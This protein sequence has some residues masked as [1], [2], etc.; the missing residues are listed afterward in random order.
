MCVR[1]TNRDTES[2]V[3]LTT[4]ARWGLILLKGYLSNTT[5]LTAMMGIESHICTHIYVHPFLRNLPNLPLKSIL[6][7]SRGLNLTRGPYHH[8]Y[9]CLPKAYKWCLEVSW[10]CSTKPHILLANITN[11]CSSWSFFKNDSLLLWDEHFHDTWTTT[12]TC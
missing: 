1:Q 10:K 5:T 6:I 3:T 12:C 9:M 11:T 7:A 4:H 2:S 8:L